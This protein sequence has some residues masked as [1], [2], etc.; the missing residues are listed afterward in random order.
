MGEVCL[1]PESPERQLSGT[2]TQVV[3]MR[4]AV[5]RNITLILAGVLLVAAVASL[6]RSRRG[7]ARYSDTFFD[8]F[9]TLVT[10]VVYAENKEGFDSY[11]Q[12]IRER[13]RELHRLYDKYNEYEGI[14]NIR[15]INENAGI[16]P[17]KVEREIVDLIIFAKDW[18]ARTGGKANIAMGSVLRIW[19]DYRE[20]GLYDPEKAK[21]PPME[22]LLEAA[23]HVDIDKVVV[24]VEHSTV[25]L[26]DKDMSLD[27]GA[28]AKG[29]AT[30]VVAR[31]MMAAGLKSGM[32][33]A[34]GN[35]RAIGKPQD[36]VRERWG[37]GIQNPVES[38]VSD[39][40]LLDVHGLDLI[41]SLARHPLLKLSDLF[42]PFFSYGGGPLHAVRLAKFLLG[43]AFSSQV[44]RDL[45]AFIEIHLGLSG[46]NDDVKNLTILVEG[47]RGDS[48]INLS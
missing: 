23:Q 12:Q 43:L 28:V 34:G 14:N 32:I 1:G 40:N 35:V 24:D 47:H 17:V 30:E 18:Y 3:H 33:S 36:G 25:Y 10:V 37:V 26:A 45:K 19:H 15:T 21:L 22:E 16:R 13:F 4:K 9:D 44:R 39:D 27:V 46:V 48:G 6:Q 8:T 5:L 20:Q 11:Y 38:I 29:Y 42:L 31:E 2:D 41:N 7:P